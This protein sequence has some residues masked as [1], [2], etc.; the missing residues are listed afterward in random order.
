[1]S[2]T[3]ADLDAMLGVPP[4]AMTCGMQDNHGHVC[5]RTF[6]PYYDAKYLN[7]AYRAHFRV[8]HAH[9]IVV[10]EE[11]PGDKRI[12]SAARGEKKKRGWRF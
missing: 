5:Q 11:E 2:Y 4:H 9:L 12:A 7:S 1:M 10:K 3:T 6:G 8:A